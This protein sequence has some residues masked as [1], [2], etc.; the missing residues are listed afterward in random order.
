MFD[1]TLLDLEAPVP[2]SLEEWVAEDP[3]G[4]RA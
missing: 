4:P 1:P 2:D 3:I